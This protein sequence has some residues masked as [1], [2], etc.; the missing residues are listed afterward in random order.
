M[1]AFV[2]RRE[3][4]KSEVTVSA[5]DKKK[6]KTDRDRRFDVRTGADKDAEDLERVIRKSQKEERKKAKEKAKEEKEM[7]K[8]LEESR[9]ESER[10][11]KELKALSST[12]GRSNPSPYS[13]E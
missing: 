1:N 11:A 10:Q 5:K 7:A 9:L 2:G 6:S 3:I 12:P 8:A 13:W 4:V